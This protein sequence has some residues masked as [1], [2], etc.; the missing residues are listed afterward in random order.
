MRIPPDSYPVA[1]KNTAVL[2]KQAQ[3]ELL[4]LSHPHGIRLLRLGKVRVE[5]PV[6][7]SVWSFFF[8]L[9]LVLAAVA[10][11]LAFFGLAPEAAVAAA[12]LSISNAGPFLQ[13]V[14]P[15]APSY[16]DMPDGA[17][18][19]LSFAMLAGRVELLALL[20]LMNPAYWRR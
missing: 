8:L 14:A 2:F 11:A 10:L 18:L 16:A 6:V 9:I 4:R 1:N 15:G 12:V 17:K 19:V 3:R 5:N 20:S 7:W 13:A